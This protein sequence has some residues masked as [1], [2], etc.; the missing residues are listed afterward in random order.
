MRREALKRAQYASLIIAILALAGSGWLIYR[1]VQEQAQEQADL[2]AGKRVGI[3]AGHSGYDSGAVCPDGLTE[4]EVN[5]DI[6][7]RTAARLRRAGAQVDLLQ[8]FDPR[9]QGYRADAFVSIHADTCEGDYSGFKVARVE[10]SAVPEAEDRLVDCLWQQYEAVTG[11][12]Q[13]PNTITFDMRDY[14]AFREI[15]P[16]T[17]GAIIEVGFLSGDRWLLTKQPDRVAQGV[18]DGI[19]CF[20]AESGISER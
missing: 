8:E 10:H 17:P 19:L 7:E 3:V 4:A 2:A 18:A 13:H 6:A 9:L 14:H 12:A 11:L 20:L 15:D 16:Q 1:R 5:L